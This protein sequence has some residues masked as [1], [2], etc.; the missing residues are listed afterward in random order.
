MIN[1]DFHIST[2]N[3]KKKSDEVSVSK[4]MEGIFMGPQIRELMH[5][6]KCQVMM[7]KTESAA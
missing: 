7:D 6:N 4:V 3:K 2:E 1:Q 5:Y